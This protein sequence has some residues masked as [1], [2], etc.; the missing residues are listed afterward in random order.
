M[1]PPLNRYM[2][3]FLSD[4]ECEL[5]LVCSRNFTYGATQNMGDAAGRN[6]QFTVH[7]FPSKAL[8]CAGSVRNIERDTIVRWEVDFG[9]ID[10]QELHN[11]EERAVRNVVEKLGEGVIW[12]PGQEVSLI[13]FENWK[14][15]YVRIESG[16]EMVDEI[17]RQDGWTKEATFCAKL[18]D[19][20]SDSK[21]G[22]VASKLASQMSDD[23]W[24][25][26]SH[27]TRNVLTGDPSLWSLDVHCC[28][29]YDPL[30]T[31][32]TWS[33]VERH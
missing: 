32:N 15:E 18:V 21:V 3:L 28:S 14:G 31:K 24:D 20:K 4:F 13:R 16:E 5:F 25:S 7:F 22:N 19:L 26:R 17:D 9:E 2:H 33:S 8:L 23:A 10:P 12:G 11:M 6:F 30:V 1:E 29:T 27:T